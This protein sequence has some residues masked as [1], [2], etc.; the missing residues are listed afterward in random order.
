MDSYHFVLIHLL[1]NESRM[2]NLDY[3]GYES[4]NPSSMTTL[5]IG[6]LNLTHHMKS[7]YMTKQRYCKD[8]NNMKRE[9]LILTSQARK[10]PAKT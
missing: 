6:R 8:F 5:G 10:H 4:Y 2:R 3:F 1:N 7:T 9:R